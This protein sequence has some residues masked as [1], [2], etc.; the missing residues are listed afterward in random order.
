[1]KH[2]SQNILKMYSSE[3]FKAI[4]SFIYKRLVAL[5]TYDPTSLPPL[6]TPITLLTPT[7]PAIEMEDPTYGL[8][9]VT[10]H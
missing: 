9:K 2:S 8:R 7:V 4:I 10:L 5:D 1:M 3:I 6:R